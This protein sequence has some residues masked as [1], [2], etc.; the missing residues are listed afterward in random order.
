MW[1]THPRLDA[2]KS[3][4]VPENR[5]P[6]PLTLLRVKL[7]P[8]DVVMLN[9]GNE[10]TAIRRARQ[11]IGVV[12]TAKVIAVDEEE[13]TPLRDAMKEGWLTDDVNFIPA[14]VRDPSVF[15]GWY[16]ALDLTVNPP[17]AFRVVALLSAASQHL[18]PKADS[19]EGTPLA[20][21]LFG[22]GL[23]HGVLND[24]SHAIRKCADARQDDLGAFVQVSRLVGDDR[25]AAALFDGTRNRIEIAHSIV[26]DNHSI[27]CL[28]LQSAGSEE[29]AR[30]L[31]RR[32]DPDLTHWSAYSTRVA[33]HCRN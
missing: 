12:R 11:N 22:K 33:R 3:K 10:A 19:E 30:S 25:L 5:E 28:D 24:V 7:N 14:H 6:E 23:V 17:Q 16:E 32:G 1:T 21:H 15:I 9:R 20:E 13:V 27:H 8:E 29:L 2:L 31:G 26:D 4:E 18:H